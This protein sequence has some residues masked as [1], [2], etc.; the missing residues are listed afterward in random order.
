MLYEWEGLWLLPCTAHGEG[1]ERKIAQLH[2]TVPLRFPFKAFVCASVQ[3]PKL[4]KRQRLVLQ[5]LPENMLLEMLMNRVQAAG[6]PHTS[7]YYAVC[8]KCTSTCQE[9]AEERLGDKSSSA[10]G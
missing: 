10:R 8:A 1:S 9:K 3:A 7:A 5:S 2:R 4:D 6:L